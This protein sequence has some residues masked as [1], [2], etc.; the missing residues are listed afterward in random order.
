MSAPQPNASRTEPETKA[1]PF[2]GEHPRITKHFKEEMW[3]LLHPCPVMGP[4]TMDW[5][6]SAEA[7]VRL[8]NTRQGDEP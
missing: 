4:M 5:R 1:C 6:E 2:C 7:L 3:R 8:W